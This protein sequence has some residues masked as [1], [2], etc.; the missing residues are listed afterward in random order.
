MRLVPGPV[1]GSRLAEA[2]TAFSNAD[3]R[4]CQSGAAGASDNAPAPPG[5]SRGQWLD[6]HGFPTLIAGQ[7]R[8]TLEQTVI[9]HCGERQARPV[10]EDSRKEEKACLHT[11][12]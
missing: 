12:R 5:D 6:T 1:P 9:I 7:E 4:E 8:E 10:E 2:S 3:S 11:L